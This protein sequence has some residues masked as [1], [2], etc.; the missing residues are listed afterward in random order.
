MKN[1]RGAIDEG[2]MTIYRGILVTII[3]FFILGVSAFAYS[4]HLDVGDAEAVIM[5]KKVVNC[6]APEGSVDLVSI[7]KYKDSDNFLKEYCGIQ[8]A[9]RFYV[10]V[11]F[12]EDKEELSF[13]DSFLVLEQGQKNIGWLVEI[14]K[15]EDATQNIRKYIPGVLEPF[16]SPVIFNKDSDKTGTMVMGVVVSV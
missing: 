14:S 6:L 12:I 7:E 15:D 9:E 8:G 2:I 5:A 1:K 13:E 3:A 11:E 16:R 4:Y 10:R